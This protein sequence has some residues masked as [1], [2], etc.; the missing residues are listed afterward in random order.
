MPENGLTQ[1]L[2]SLRTTT[3]T[4]NPQNNTP[5]NTQQ[6]ESHRLAEQQ[7]FPEPTNLS[8]YEI[9]FNKPYAF[10]YF[11]FGEDLQNIQTYNEKAKEIDSFIKD[12]IELF[13]L[14]NNLN[15][16][17]EIINEIIIS[18]ESNPNTSGVVKMEKLY[19]WI[20]DV[21]R[22]QREEMKKRKQYA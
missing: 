10:E 16:Y 13:S 22:P 8:E 17:K 7:E 3:Q 20:K 19:N 5:Q 11:Q 14:E 12:E 2:T 1:S 9:A 15:T 18:I 6:Y 4:G 21:L